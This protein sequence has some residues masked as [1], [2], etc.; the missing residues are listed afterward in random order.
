MHDLDRTTLEIGDEI[1]NFEFPQELEF[2][3]QESPFNEVEEAEL[4]AELLEITDEAELDQFIGSLIKKAGKAA[5][6][7]IRSPLGRHVGGLIKGAIKKG[8]PLAGSALGGAIAP[9]VGNA[10]GSKLGSAAGQIFG[11]ELESA[12][13][14]EMEFEVAR[15]L[16]RLA[17]SAVQNVAQAAD[18]T[19]PKAAATAAVVAAAKTHAPGLVGANTGGGRSSNGRPTSGRWYRRGSKIIVVGL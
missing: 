11:L 1:T 3:D 16:V 7:L 2:G 6:G 17:G 19:D 4:A 10:I 12:G 5:R 13:A 18:T 8:L 9:G 14:E 15:K